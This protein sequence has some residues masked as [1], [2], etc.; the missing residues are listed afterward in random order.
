MKTARM[1]LM[2]VCVLLMLSAFAAAKGRGEHPAYLRALS[3][4]REARAQLHQIDGDRRVNSEVRLALDEIEAA[5]QEIKDEGIDD[6]KSL[7]DHPPIDPAWDRVRRLERVRDLL[8]KARGDI[9]REPAGF[10]RGLKRRTEAH[11]QS[12]RYAMQHALRIEQHEHDPAR[13]DN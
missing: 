6:G 2:A 7:D 1:F 8:E 10:G 5:M 4:L 11:L 13:H 9:A 12:A 3:G